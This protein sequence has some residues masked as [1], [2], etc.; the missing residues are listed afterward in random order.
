M[1]SKPSIILAGLACNPYFI[2]GIAAVL[3]F[4]AVLLIGEYRA[5]RLWEHGEIAQNVYD[6]KGF[7]AISPVAKS[8]R[9]ITDPAVALR[10]TS[11]QAPGFVFLL[12]WQWKWIG[13]SPVAWLGICMVQ[14][15]LTASIVLAVM[16]ITRMWFDWKAAVWAGWAAC[17]MPLYA[18]YS[19]LLTPAALIF[20][21]SPWSLLGWLNLQRSRSWLL[22]ALV[23][24]AS[25]YRQ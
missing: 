5:P 13:R 2:F 19:A 1:R 15:L 24:F 11:S 9:E 3:H 8:G 14:S 6:G 20:A 10:P 18:V 22:A 17:L 23:G 7:T 12:Y 16:R 21:L 25:G 4:V